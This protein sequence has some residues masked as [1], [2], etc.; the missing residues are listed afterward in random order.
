[1][2]QS[3]K[4]SSISLNLHSPQYN[5]VED[6]GYFKI[7]NFRL[8]DN[9]A[10]RYLLN[11]NTNLQWDVPRGGTSD[12]WRHLTTYPKTLNTNKAIYTKKHSDQ[13]LQKSLNIQKVFIEKNDF[14]NT[15]WTEDKLKDLINI[16]ENN[17]SISHI[18]NISNI[19]LDKENKMITF[20]TNIKKSLTNY[21]DTKTITMPII[22]TDFDYL[23]QGSSLSD[24]YWEHLPTGETRYHSTK[25]TTKLKIS[26]KFY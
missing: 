6:K 21:Y 25:P 23:I 4:A 9:T 8:Y 22:V 10:K 26:R 2:S 3:P 5:D 7:T 16:I 19:S 13:V 20:D 24:S 14:D 18:A 17:N 12:D 15:I 1:M 11:Q